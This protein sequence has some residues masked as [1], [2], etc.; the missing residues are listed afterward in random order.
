MLDSCDVRDS[1]Y[2]SQG[3]VFENIDDMVTRADKQVVGM[4]HAQGFSIRCVDGV[5]LERSSLL[6][7]SNFV[8]DHRLKVATSSMADK[9]NKQCAGLVGRP[10]P[11]RRGEGAP[12]TDVTM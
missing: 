9:I 1:N 10:E 6:Q 8:R 12:D 11:A 3:F 5:R 4:L 7:L 2:L